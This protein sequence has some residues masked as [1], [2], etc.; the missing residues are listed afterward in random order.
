MKNLSPTLNWR[1]FADLS[2]E[3]KVPVEAMKFDVS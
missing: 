2:D 3:L 1:R